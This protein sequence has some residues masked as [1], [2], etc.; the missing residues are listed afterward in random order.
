MHRNVLFARSCAR[1]VVRVL[2]QGCS[3]V[4]DFSTANI[5]MFAARA[6]GRQSKHM[7]LPG[8][9]V[10]G[11]SGWH[12]GTSDVCSGVSGRRPTAGGLPAR[13]RPPPPARRGPGPLGPYGTHG[14]HR[15]VC[16]GGGSGGRANM[17]TVDGL[18]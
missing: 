13:R 17:D 16:C 8:F 3:Q 10:A 9:W 1:V 14:L 4:I 15:F 11:W 5:S 12:E 18:N 2:G 6:V 7:L